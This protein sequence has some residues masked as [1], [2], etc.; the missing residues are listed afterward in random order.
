MPGMAKLTTLLVAIL[1]TTTLC[2]AAD[3]VRAL[4]STMQQTAT[5]LYNSLSDDQ[6]KQ[7]VLPF[8][9]PQRLQ[10]NFTPGKRAGI[11]ISNLTAPQQEQAVA[12]ITNFTS[13]YGAQKSLAVANQD[14]TPGFGHYYLVFFG[15]PALD[16]NYAWRIAEHHLTLVNVEVADG[17]PTVFGPILLGANPPTLWDQEEDAMIALYAA[18]TP[19]ERTKATNPGHGE[20]TKKLIGDSMKIADLNPEAKQK[21]QA[22]FAG[23]MQFFSAPI[24]ERITKIVENQGGL[25]AM[26]IAF[27]GPAE[28]RCAAGGR[29]D[30]KMAGGNFLCDYESSRGHIHLSMKATA[31]K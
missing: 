19:E 20:S 3:G 4:P 17:Q 7:A 27:Y 13:D 22:I 31:G 21:A 9:G 28:K 16:A 8:N 23:R 10:E 25:D 6:R 12:L 29:W 2:K 15:N 24:Q 26:K 18:L 5:S 30:F 14:P 1:F 11:L